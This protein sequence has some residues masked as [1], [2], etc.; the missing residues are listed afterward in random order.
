MDFGAIRCLEVGPGPSFLEPPFHPDVEGLGNLINTRTR[1]ATGTGFSTPEF[2]FMTSYLRLFLLPILALG[3][4]G[5]FQG[6]Q[7]QT[8]P[9]P[10]RFI[11]QSQEVGMFAGYLSPGTG[12]FG[13]GPKPGP[14]WGARYSVNVGGPFGLEGTVTHSPTTRDIID[15]GRVEGDRV[16]GDMPSQLVMIDGRLR[17]TLTGDRTWHDLAP[18]LMTGGGVVFDVSNDNSDQ[19]VLL[20]GD[21]F[22]MGTS[23]VGLLGGGIRWFPTDRFLIR[24]D[25]SLFLW[26]LKTPRGYSDPEREFVGVSEKE[27]V[28][29]PSFSL[30]VSFRF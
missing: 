23:F 10:F 5:S 24:G 8:I 18:F 7:G 15:P 2:K 28:S 12:R 29:G 9:S 20:E 16:V 6:L 3:L 1:R 22:S 11:D 17:F 14:A 30:G 21:R 26:R 13:F 4:P 19:E 27:W 25:L